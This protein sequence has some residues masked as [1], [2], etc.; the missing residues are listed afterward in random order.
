MKHN[1]NKETAQHHAEIAK[2]QFRGNKNHEE[3]NEEMTSRNA[4]STEGHDAYINEH[5]IEAD[6]KNSQKHNSN[7]S[8]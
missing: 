1:K 5:S 4:D 6:K 8:S 3:E 2:D 7:K